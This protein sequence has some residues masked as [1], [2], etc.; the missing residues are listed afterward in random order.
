MFALKELL[1]ANIAQLSKASYPANA[2]GEYYSGYIQG[3]VGD[4][5]RSIM[6]TCFPEDD[7]L[8]TLLGQYYDDWKAGDTDAQMLMTSKLTGHFMLDIVHCMND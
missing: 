4:N 6:A 5:V 3:W 2:T 1:E 7:R 8:A